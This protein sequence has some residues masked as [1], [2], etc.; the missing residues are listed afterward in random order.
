MHVGTVLAVTMLLSGFASAAPQATLRFALPGGAA[1]LYSN[2][3][4]PQDPLP[5]R[6]WK[7]AVFSFPNG[8]T[9][10]LLSRVG[11]SRAGGG[12]QMEPPN[13]WNI[14]PSGQY[15]IVMRNDQG[16][17]FMGQGRP[18]AVLN[19][20]YCSMIEIK[21]AVLR[22]STPERFAEQGGNRVKVSNGE[23]MPKLQ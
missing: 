6:T 4:N 3:A 11:E 22:P 8:L 10:D 15:V 23:Q 2:A 17:V 16:T 5:R 12:T 14:S 19:R 1:V 20:E 7:K 21:P 18:E 13:K 9:F